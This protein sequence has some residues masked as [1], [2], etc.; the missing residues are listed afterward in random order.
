MVAKAVPLS[1]PL[2]LPR[3]AATART[4]DEALVHYHRVRDEIR[5]FIE[6]LPDSLAGP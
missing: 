4:E 6:T 2:Y 1:H 5:D 3:L